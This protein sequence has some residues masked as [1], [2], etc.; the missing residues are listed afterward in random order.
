MWMTQVLQKK[1]QHGKPSGIWHLC[2][3]S[4]E[5]GG[6][7]AGCD[8]E[9]RSPE[10]A[11]ACRE[12]KIAVGAVTGFPYEP[13]KITINGVEHELDG[14]KISH[15][16][17]CELAGKPVHAS[18]TYRGPRK[19]DSERSGITHA[20]KSIDLETGMIFTCVVTGNA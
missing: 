7:Y 20:G 17:I 15:E 19:G 8:H 13:A 9:H 5:G 11:D 14:D 12:A 16:Q 18:V 3:S 10:E 2:A 6:F 4:D 1:D